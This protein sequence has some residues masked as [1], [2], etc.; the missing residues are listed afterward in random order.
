MIGFYSE[1]KIEDKTKIVKLI[2]TKLKDLRMDTLEQEENSEV[3]V[4]Q[5]FQE[6]YTNRL[7]PIIRSETNNYSFVEKN[8]R[9][10]K[11]IYRE[12]S[13]KKDINSKKMTKAILAP[14]F[15]MSNPNKPT[16][17][18][19]IESIYKSAQYQGNHKINYDNFKID[20]VGEPELIY[21]NVKL[22]M[23]DIKSIVI[24]NGFTGDFSSILRGIFEGRCSELLRLFKNEAKIEVDK[25]KDNK[26]DIPFEEAINKYGDIKLLIT[27]IEK[28]SVK[29]KSDQSSKDEIKKSKD[30][31]AQSLYDVIEKTFGVLSKDLAETEDLKKQSLLNNLAENI[32]FKVDNNNIFPIFKVHHHDNLQKYFA[33]ALF[34]KKNEMYDIVR[35]YPDFLFIHKILFT[36]RNGLKHSEKEETLQKIK[37]EK[38]LEYK[39]VAYRIILIILKIK[40]KDI[41]QKNVE[42]DNDSYLTNAY[43]DLENEFNIDI[44]NQLP[45]EVKDNLVFINYCINELDFKESQYNIVKE[46]LNN[47]YSSFELILRKKIKDLPPKVSLGYL[48]NRLEEVQNLNDMGK[49]LIKEIVLLRGHGSPS[50]EDILKMNKE[51]LVGLKEESY[52]L[53]KKLIGEF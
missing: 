20:T 8:K 34:Y 44:L 51:K 52:K 42:T 4:C 36:F 16:K 38:L 10:E 9:Y 7:L 21:M 23:P 6:A 5:F 33:K 53:I 30:M 29:I 41:E 37:K 31:L 3:I 47:L 35:E 24:T 22:F 26:L 49:K 28:Q 45:Q 17:S 39:D 12:I 25:I 40:L 15:K 43:I 18:D 46:V 27:E 1:N 48:A 14:G 19:V 2:V 32:G 50:N 11:D 13:F